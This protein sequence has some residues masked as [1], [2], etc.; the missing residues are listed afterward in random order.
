MRQTWF[1]SVVTFIDMRNPKIAFEPAK[2]LLSRI[3]PIFLGFLF[4]LLITGCNLLEVGNDG[5]AV[6]ASPSV[7]AP[8]RETK[9][10]ARASEPVST[11]SQIALAPTPR[12]VVTKSS[13][14]A[15]QRTEKIVWATPSTPTTTTVLGATPVLARST[16]PSQAMD[17][18]RQTQDNSIAVPPPAV[19]ALIVKG[20]PRPPES[21]RAG[22]PIVLVGLVFLVGALGL[23][24][25]A[26]WRRFKGGSTGPN[27][28]EKDE[29][30]AG[31]GLLIKE[32]SI[33]RPQ[34][35]IRDDPLPA[36]GSSSE[37]AA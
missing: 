27:V 26:F 22:W 25:W 5:K 36:R 34:F 6:Q 15:N 4:S 16:P 3:S 33:S 13:F 18:V 14:V 23:V 24:A 9:P 8:T 1:A 28:G 21:H 10:V 37:S 35:D 31:P 2:A 17:S 7:S 12:I 29:L 32:S 20:T 30:L 11:T 19:D